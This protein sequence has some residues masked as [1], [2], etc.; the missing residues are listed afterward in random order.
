MI[1]LLQQETP[2]FIHPDLWLPSYS[3]DLD[4]VD[5]RIWGMMRNRMYQT[6]VREIV[7]VRQHFIDTWNDSSQSIVDDAVDEW[8]KRLQTCVNEKDIFNT[9]C[10]I[11]R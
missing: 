3:P 11:L 2:K 6:P 9:C 10:N 8:H 1:E 4:P 7:Y 5:Y